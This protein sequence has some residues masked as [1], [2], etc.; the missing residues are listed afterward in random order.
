M[1][2][3]CITKLLASFLAFAMTFTNFALLG[4]T[5][6]VALAADKTNL[7]GQATNIRKTEVEFDAYFQDER[8]SNSY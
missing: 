3:K 7:E 2:Q 8:S 6:S 4:S 1:K 5:A